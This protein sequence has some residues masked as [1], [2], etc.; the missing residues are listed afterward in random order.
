MCYE[1]QVRYVR[2]ARA[3][4]YKPYD[5]SDWG[6]IR[7]AIEAGAP[8]LRRKEPT[9]EWDIEPCE[10]GDE[11]YG[12]V[13]AVSTEFDYDPCWDVLHD[14]A[15]VGVLWGLKQLTPPGYECDMLDTGSEL[16]ID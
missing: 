4:I 15:A 12:M 2:K 13:L 3:F 5:D 11:V 6:V 14:A 1:V 9:F 16:D 7:A 8:E 10:A